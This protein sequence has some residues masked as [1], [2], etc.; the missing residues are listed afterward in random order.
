TAPSARMPSGARHDAQLRAQDDADERRQ[1]AP[2]A[3]EAAARRRIGRLRAALVADERAPGAVGT[4]REVAGDPRE[5]GAVERREACG[6]DLLPRRLAGPEAAD[7]A[8]RDLERSVLAQQDPLA[9][10]RQ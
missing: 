8:E 2:V 5:A 6:V 9:A 4:Q 10:R 1:Q 7:R 3:Q